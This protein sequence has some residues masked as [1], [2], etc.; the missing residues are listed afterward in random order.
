MIEKIVHT[1]KQ[2]V[3]AMVDIDN[4][5]VAEL[6]VIWA[7]M[8]VFVISGSII[9]SNADARWLKTKKPPAR[10]TAPGYPGWR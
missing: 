6:S 10:S 9:G 5:R 8:A 3:K 2:T 4:A 1:A 7:G